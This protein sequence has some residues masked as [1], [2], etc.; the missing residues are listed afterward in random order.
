MTVKG[1]Q[2]AGQGIILLM[3]MVMG[4]VG[5]WNT[6]RTS[7]LA[8][9]LGSSTWGAVQ[10][11]NAQNALWQLRFGIPQFILYT[12][13]GARDKIVADEVRWYKEIDDNLAAFRKGRHSVEELAALTKL[14]KVFKQYKDARPRWFQ[15]YGEWKLEEAA[16]WHQKTTM[17]YGGGTITGLSELI[18]L[19]QKTAEALE[20]DAIEQTAMLEIVLVVLVILT[21]V[22]V[23]L[24]SFVT[25][26]SIMG[27]LGKAVSLANR[28]AAGDLTVQ[29]EVDSD[30]EFGKLLGALKTMDENLERMVADIRSGAESIRSSAEEVASGNAS[31]SQRTEE[32]AA[33]LEETASSMEQLTS[34]VRE[35][36]QSAHNA[37]ALAKDANQ[38]A[39]RGGAVVNTVV[40]TMNEIQGSSKKIADIIGVIDGIAF[41]TNILALNAAVEAA[42]AG[43]QGRGFAVVASE[44]RSLAQRSADAAKEIKA[45]IGASVKKVETGTRQVEDA[46]K[47][48][49]E[50]VASVEKVTAIIDHISSASREQANGI[51]Q[52][53][54]AIGQMDQVVQQNAAVVEQA[55]AA[56]ESMQGNAQ[57]LYHAVSLFKL[58]GTAPAQA[59]V[60][61]HAQPSVPSPASA[62]PRLAPSRKDIALPDTRGD[63]RT[64]PRQSKADDGE[65][66]EF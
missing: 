55:A 36:T 60:R 35:N 40:A 65:W 39:A 27:P 23:L 52:V 16:E 22:L 26:R 3:V 29:I 44:V 8:G 64:G 33:T 31:L 63:A 51:E 21:V 48:M 30:D 46:G 59:D 53:N 34:A 2:V 43:E 57:Q 58:S 1:K 9:E 61:R 13:K 5:I 54:K 66:K 19:Q 32:Q 38:V 20:K 18:Q 37:N 4:G 25:I 45:L 50:I 14:E 10:L 17:P 6:M 28:V 11:A 15:L 62:A 7:Q 12:D 56:A 24:V 49:G 47:T 42:R 41:Q